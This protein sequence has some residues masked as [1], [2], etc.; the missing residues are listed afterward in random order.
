MME[1]RIC[2]N[3]KFKCHTTSILKNGY[4]RRHKEC[5]NCGWKFRTL[6]LFDDDFDKYI[7]LVEE[8][9]KI[10]GNFIKK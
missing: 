6:E 4:V 9:K 5:K 2:K 1:C 10:I 8:L 3:S 7:K